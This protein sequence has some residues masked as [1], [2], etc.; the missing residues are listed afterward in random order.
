MIC[1]L[2]FFA[3]SPYPHDTNQLEENEGK[4]AVV[5]DHVWYHAGISEDSQAYAQDRQRLINWGW[6]RFAIL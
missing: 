2:F 1:I 3:P 4:R 6:R 5:E